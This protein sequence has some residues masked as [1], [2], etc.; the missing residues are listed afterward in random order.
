M[1]FWPRR[2]CMRHPRWS[3]Q[4]VAGHCYYLGPHLVG[5]KN[6]AWRRRKK[7]WKSVS[8]MASYACERDHWRLT[9]TAWT[10]K[11]VLKNGQL[12]LWTSPWVANANCQYQL[13]SGINQSISQ[14]IVKYSQNFWEVL[15]IGPGIC[16][17]QWPLL[18]LAFGP[19]VLR[20]PPVVRT[21]AKLAFAFFDLFLSF[22]FLCL[23]LF[24]H[25]GD[26]QEA[27]ILFPLIFWLN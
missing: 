24:I 23:L 11:Y 25:F 8:T 6:S 20:A 1:V 12:R 26:T 27:E 14:F 18:S 19:G 4:C 5:K 16:T 9:Q 3:L 21:E 15:I 10:K 17:D 13:S 22:F 2:L 7:V